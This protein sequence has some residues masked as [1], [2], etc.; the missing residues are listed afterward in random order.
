MTCSEIDFDST[1]ARDH[2][3]NNPISSCIKHLH[4]A[5]HHVIPS[6]QVNRELTEQYACFSK[7]QSHWAVAEFFASMASENVLVWAV[8]KPGSLG[9][10]YGDLW[11]VMKTFRQIILP[12]FHVNTCTIFSTLIPGP[13]SCLLMKFIRKISSFVPTYKC[14]TLCLFFIMSFLILIYSIM[15]SI[16]TIITHS[17]DIDWFHLMW[18]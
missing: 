9:L 5:V 1:K 8:A 12:Y 3:S 7:V 10:A 14:P 17:L 18:I 4:A 15:V 13:D 6:V 2:Y 11:Q 16:P